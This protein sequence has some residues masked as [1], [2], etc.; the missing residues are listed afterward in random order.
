MFRSRSLNRACL[1][2]VSA[3]LLATAS[4]QAQTAP[5]PA[6][7]QHVKMVEGTPHKFTSKLQRVVELN[8]TFNFHHQD[9]KNL[10]AGT[11]KRIA[12]TTYA[13][14][15]VPAF[16]IQRHVGPANNSG[17]PGTAQG[18]PTPD[19]TL[20]SLLQGQVIFANQISAFGSSQL[21]ATRRTAVQT[22]IADS[23]RGYFGIHAS[24]DDQSGGNFWQW[25][26]SALHPMNYQGHGERTPGPV[27]K[28]PLMKEHIVTAGVLTAG[29]TPTAVPTS[30]DNQGEDV[31]TVEPTRNIRNE[32]YY[33]GRD[34][35]TDSVL[36]PRV[37][38]LS[39]YD[40]RNLASNALP[41]QYRRKGGNMY[42]YLY[43][44]GNGMTHY[45]P[46]GHDNSEIFANG[47]F[48]GG[49]GDWDRYF[50]QVLFFLAGYD[51]APCD[52]SC[53][54]LPI[55]AADNQLTG[56]V[57]SLRGGRFAAEPRMLSLDPAVP[58][59]R[60]PHP[61]RY[62]AVLVDATGKVAL[63]A[64]GV[65]DR[66]AFDPSRLASGVHVLRVKVDGEPAATRRY[67]LSATR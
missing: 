56:E 10:I 4:A 57:V 35:R 38:V 31:L 64:R 9:S 49:V 15:G 13:I 21:G 59:F 20:D 32:W 61:V 33:F 45:L 7:R 22:A 30:T 54:G 52:S 50:A 6:A 8:F 3:A 44:V 66:F 62:D 47:G 39:M 48:D 46:A 5:M 28:N 1:V 53:L 17:V 14:N 29:M 40:P 60:Y 37:T 23:G 25:F 27:Y 55:V 12:D 11:L 36:G 63:R 24:G 34:I 2:T 43:Q 42:T 41:S 18:L 67:M 51:S 16:S 58:G 65:G 19:F 26:R